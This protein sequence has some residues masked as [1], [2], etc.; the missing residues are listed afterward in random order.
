MNRIR[1]Y[2]LV[3]TSLLALSVLGQDNIAIGQWRTHLPYQ[4]VIDVEVFGNKVFAATPYELF[5]F[6]KEDNSIN[7]MNKISG[8]SDVGISTI[9]Y[10]KEQDLLFVAYTNTNVDLID[11][12]GKVTNMSDIKKKNIMGNKCINN[13]TFDG[14]LAYVACGFGIVVFDL[15]RREVKDTYYIGAQGDMIFV[16][17]IAFYNG[18][19]YAS[20]DEGI[21]HAQKDAPNLANYAA[22][23]FDSGLL[24]PHLPYNEMEVFADRL[25]L[26][27]DGGNEKDTIFVYDGQ[28]WDRFSNGSYHQISELRATNDKFIVTGN[29][30]NVNI[31][32]AQL[33][34]TVVYNPGGNSI[35]PWS[36]TIDASGCYW[37]GDNMRGMVESENG[38]NGTDI[39]PNGPFTQSVFDLH[40]YG[41]QVW[42]ATG[43]HTSTWAKRYLKEGVFRFDGSWKCFNRTL[44]PDFENL[45]DFV[46]VATDPRN[47]SITYVGTW[48][49]GLLKIENDKLVAIY[50]P[51]NSS[52]DYWM[53]DPTKVLIS[54]L[55]FD[56]KGNLWVANSGAPNLLSVLK[57][58]GKWQSFNLGGTTSGMDISKLTVDSHDLKW[59]IRRSGQENQV[60][61]FNDN[62]TLDDS[63]D[64]MVKGLSKNSGGLPGSVVNC[65]AVDINGVVWLGT[66]MGPCKF[67]DSRKLFTTTNYQA[68]RPMVDRN[69]GTG[70]ADPLF[71]GSNVLSMAVD[72]GGNKWFG[73]ETGV[74]VITDKD[75]QPTLRHWFHTD[76]SPILSN[77]V[78]SMAIN[79]DGEVFFGTENGVIS[80]KGEAADP[81][82]VITDVVV[83]P[84]PVRPGYDGYVGIKGLVADAL[85]KITSVDGG[86]VT[87]LQ[88]E[89]GQAVWDCTTI[90]GKK[91]APGVYL[92]F[93]STKDGGNRFATKILVMN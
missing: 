12:Q 26:N 38:W 72:G 23:T 8:L 71:D 67:D 50:T 89:G 79:A 62:G 4:K 82:P 55:G 78:N 58:D 37:I 36:A 92:I 34:K 66:D 53:S 75:V 16:T 39:I 2:F 14:H 28:R 47:P 84:N 45:S 87:Q 65:I 51:E 74:Y 76:N 21:Y 5:Y 27:Y 93:I 24:H 49:D 10:N 46:C 1:Y 17:D 57:T 60:L 52:L 63:S 11:R 42:I 81:E 43:G 19:I 48:G 80:Y 33:Q 13:V 3:L 22:W 41:D 85:V 20:T 91:V 15:K 6:D 90:D 31:Y 30:S 7:I 88:S 77:A 25:Y 68:T 29:Y 61:V 70:Q 54:G 32:D 9:R 40:A 69:D 56:S 86:F 59:I 35:V 83:Y 18:K 44:D 64:D 73:L